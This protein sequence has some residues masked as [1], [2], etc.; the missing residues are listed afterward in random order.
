ME[1]PQESSDL[2]GGIR[3]PLLRLVGKR[4]PFTGG[5]ERQHGPPVHCR[6]LPASPTLNLPG[7]V[8]RRTQDG[9][10]LAVGLGSARRTKGYHTVPARASPWPAR[11][12]KKQPCA[13]L[14]RSVTPRG[15]CPVDERIPHRSREGVPVAREGEHARPHSGPNQTPANRSTREG[16]VATGCG[17]T[18]MPTACGIPRLSRGRRSRIRVI[19]RDRRCRSHPDEH[20]G[21]RLTRLSL[22]CS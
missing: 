16:K 18:G 6:Q 10:K 20:S 5:S 22:L 13:D 19:A 4:Q 7:T 11:A 21:V 8:R 15:P 17:I 3:A 14:G 9:E 12:V 1:R 2:G